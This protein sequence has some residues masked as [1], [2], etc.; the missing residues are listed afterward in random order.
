VISWWDHSTDDCPRGETQLRRICRR[1]FHF[2][3][4]EIVLDAL[5]ECSLSWGVWRC[6]S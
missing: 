3:P 5:V 2:A 4:I 1:N 6:L